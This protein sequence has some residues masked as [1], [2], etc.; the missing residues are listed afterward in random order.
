MTN[1]NFVSENLNKNIGNQN[2][3]RLHTK[4]FSKISS[5]QIKGHLSGLKKYSM[6]KCV[7]C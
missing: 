5:I 2:K 7:H 1:A 6:T 3:L 4:E